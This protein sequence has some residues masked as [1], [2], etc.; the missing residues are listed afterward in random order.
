M[1]KTPLPVDEPLISFSDICYILKKKRSA[2]FFGSCLIAFLSL[3]FAFSRPLLHG[4]KGKFREKGKTEAQNNSITRLIFGNQQNSAGSEAAASMLS[5]PLL[6][7]VAKEL[8]LQGQLTE[9]GCTPGFF[10]KIGQK[11][12]V[13]LSH[14]RKKEES[15]LSCP[16]RSLVIQDIIYTRE[17]TLPLEIEFTT[18]QQFHVFA[19]GKKVAEGV[20][21][22]PIK[23]ERFAFTLFPQDP[24][25]L[26][27]RKF[28]LTL[29]PLNKVANQLANSL[30][31]VPDKDDSTLLVL[32]Y[33][34]PDRKIAC[35]IV[36]HIMAAHQESLE[37]ENDRVSSFQLDYLQKRQ[38]EMLEQQT[39]LLDE[40]AKNLSSDLSQTG[41]TS[42]EKEM[43]FLYQTRIKSKE[44]LQQL[45]LKI[46]RLHMLSKNQEA[47]IAQASGEDLSPINDSLRRLADLRMQRDALSLSIAQAPKTVTEDA[48]AHFGEQIKQLEDAHLMIQEIEEL[49]TAIEHNLPP[50][51]ST[52]IAQNPYLLVADWLKKMED[53]K[54][55]WENA[56]ILIK[57]LKKREW[58]K[59]KYTF[60]S[61][62]QNLKRLYT[63]NEKLLQE[64]L[65][66]PGQ[67]RSEF[68]GLTYE[69]AQQLLVDYLKQLNALEKT[70]NEYVFIL[71]QLQ[72]PAFEIGCL[73]STLSDPISREL[74]QKSTSLSLILCDDE[75]YSSKEKERSK[76]DLA[77]QKKFLQE[78]L[79]QTSKIL[80]L[81]T[82]LLQKKILSLQTIM[83]ELAHETI[84]VQEKHVH[85]FI[86]SQLSQMLQQKEQLEHVLQEI[87]VTMA[88]L[89][90]KWIHEQL[91]K[92]KVDM[93]KTIVSELTQMVEAKNIA[94]N[95]VQIQSAP[96]EPAFSPLLPSP[97]HLALFSV[98]GAFLG[99]FF[100]SGFFV[101][102]ALMKGVD[103]TPENLV[104][105][106]LPVVGTLSEKA[107][108]A[109]PLTDDDLETLR[110]QVTF[111]EE[112]KKEEEGTFGILILGKTPD[113]SFS[114]AE[115]MARRD[116]R[117]LVIPLSFHEATQTEGLLPY[118]EGRS[119]TIPILSHQDFSYIPAGG[120]S[121]YSTELLGSSPFAEL[122]RNWKKEYDWII[123]VSSAEPLSA[124]AVSLIP[125]GDTLT[126]ALHDERLHELE[127][128]R[129]ATNKISFIFT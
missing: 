100:T 29:L 41:F 14:W 127:P 54:V 72:D 78:H 74:I 44:K 101:S 73:S 40:H 110:N 56:P 39:A 51:P 126:V 113:F 79:E 28:S 118:L 89:P 27:K 104:L 80:N 16:T 75:K 102:Q 87:N 111:M 49:T 24:S 2:I 23:T 57:E 99:A 50:K 76:S 121:R 31:I 22:H 3:S 117:I 12:Q 43:E 82:D 109:S 129:T 11:I 52:V 115:L 59:Q 55:Q 96:L 116:Q 106:G 90:K 46:Q 62:L 33:A 93:N 85:D 68:Q 97:P 1:Q 61:Y 13:E 128:Y 48:K 7:Q 86:V 77:T 103:A 30:E 63:I 5:R 95:M 122:L 21:G 123:G 36:D 88:T 17:T 124:A 65:S 4:A 91:M 94:N 119:K 107:S 34:H 84:S 32:K 81:E 53:G 26:K 125:L 114:L 92:Q 35:C 67:D 108:E 15:P 19:E 105:S 66:H 42:F 47:S 98:L 60:L 71:K 112:R 45:N 58:E 64:R 6:A 37:K 69:S 9:M 70:Q 18:D 10:T 20:L 120:I 8:N 25:S 83:L 38:Q